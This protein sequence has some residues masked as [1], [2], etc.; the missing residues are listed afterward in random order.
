MPKLP[1]P[2][3]DEPSQARTSQVDEDESSR[4]RIAPQRSSGRSRKKNEDA[5]EQANKE[6]AAKTAYREV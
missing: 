3:E 1:N 2:I 5:G 6:K 4:S